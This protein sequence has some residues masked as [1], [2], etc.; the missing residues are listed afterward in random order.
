M[1]LYDSTVSERY[2]LA[3]FNV[4]KKGGMLEEI[5]QDATQLLA[6]KA[7]GSKLAIFLEGP[8]FTTESKV[9]LIKKAFEGK[10]HG[11]IYKLMMVLM[12]KGRIEYTR[13]ILGR[14]IELA[15]QDQ[16]IQFAEVASATE[17]TDA[18]KAKLKSALEVYTKST[19]RI[20]YR[21]EPK[22]IAG[23]RFT[24]GDLMI[25]DTVKGKLDRLRFQLQEAIR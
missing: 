17:L 13:P 14:F 7:K 9:A 4:A 15:E 6:I 8:Q 18:E 16:G 2:A 1:I 3:L 5:K 10:V 20:S 22:H 25:D 24:M 19:L 21:V 12:E 11:L 23:I